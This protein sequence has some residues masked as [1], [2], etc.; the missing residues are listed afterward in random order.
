VIKPSLLPLVVGSGV[1]S[2]WFPSATQSNTWNEQIVQEWSATKE[3]KS[4][5]RVHETILW[6]CLVSAVLF[7]FDKHCPI[8][9]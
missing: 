8:M 5:T 2:A 1:T 7:L 9:E 6:P 4:T 3:I